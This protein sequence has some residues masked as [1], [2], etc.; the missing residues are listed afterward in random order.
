MGAIAAVIEEPYCKV[1]PDEL[2]AL[3]RSHNALSR[4]VGFGPDYSMVDGKA[5]V[6]RDRSQVLKSAVGGAPRNSVVRV[7]RGRA[8][9]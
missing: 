7:V 5:C 8:S 3:V 1:G 9:A 4:S 6:R 2:A